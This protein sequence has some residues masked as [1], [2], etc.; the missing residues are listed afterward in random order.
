MY[1]TTANT[2]NAPSLGTAGTSQDHDAGAPSWLPCD[3]RRIQ[4]VLRTVGFFSTAH[5]AMST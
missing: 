2:T 1:P 4:G 5:L 3:I